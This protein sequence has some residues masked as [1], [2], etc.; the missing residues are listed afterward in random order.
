PPTDVIEIGTGNTTF[1][2]EAVDNNEETTIW[3]VSTN[4]ETVG[5]ALLE[6]GLIEGDVSAFGLFVSKVNG[7]VADWDVNQ[8]WWAFYID[9]EM[10]MYG[11]D[12]VEINVESVYA[13]IYTI[14]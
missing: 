7:L 1:Q 10:S 2:F 6:V 4:E 5:A 8:S 11:V 12:D 13:F 14:G 9:S 3:F